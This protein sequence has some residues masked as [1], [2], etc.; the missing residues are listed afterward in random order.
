[1]A[2]LREVRLFGTT[3]G[4]GNLTVDGERTVM[5][6]LVKIEWAVGTFS[7][8]VDA[9]IS[10]QGTPSGVAQTLLTLTDANTNADYYPRTPVHN[11]VG[12]ALTAA[13]GG[14]T[15]PY[16]VSGRPR[17]VVSSG[18]ATKL[19]GVIMHFEEEV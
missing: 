17:L 18:G 10:M 6:R 7:A 5:G 9:V 15:V 16:I 11:N 19:G 4:S 13:A 14:D 3:D 2:R 1:M 8:G 12:T